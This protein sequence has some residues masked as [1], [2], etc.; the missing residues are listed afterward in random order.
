MKH[1][2]YGAE[3][4]YF[5]GKARSYLRW[6]GI[7]FEERPADRAFFKEVCLPRLGR[8]IIPVLITPEDEAIQDTTLIT[9]HFEEA[10]PEPT[11]T[12]SKPVQLLVARLLELYADDW[13]LLPAMHYRWNYD[14]DVTMLEFGMNLAP[15]APLEQQREAGIKAAGP[16]AGSL[17]ALGV[18]EHNQEAIET[19]FLALLGELD[20]HFRQ[21]PFLLGGRPSLADFAFIGPFYAHLFRDATSGALMRREALTVARWVER[22]MAPSGQALGTFLPD[23][24]IAPTLEPILKR[25]MREHM[26]CLAD[27]QGA[28]EAWK[29][30][31]T[32]E[33]P[34]RAV[35]MHD[36]ELEGVTAPRA[37]RTYGSWLHQ[38]AR[39]V[40][41]A[42]ADD[43]RARAD[44][45]LDRCG[46]ALFAQTTIDVPLR[47]DN[48]HLQWQES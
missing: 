16:F 13:L 40:Y 21:H 45:L 26:P 32:G 1:V 15:E 43:D 28:M 14:A 36:F 30:G 9:D 35:G 33:P 10:V 7:D 12:P 27:T 18:H 31:H 2:L 38:R 8:P 17:P 24:E 11:F 29:Q 22:M 44:A 46:G 41:D 42:M 23:D 20:A 5:T 19:S 3:I 25:M 47:L 48:C 39:S 4:S 34:P 6:K 37:I